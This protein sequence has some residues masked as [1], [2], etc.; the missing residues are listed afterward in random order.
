MFGGNIIW[1]YFD[2]AVRNVVYL[3]LQRRAFVQLAAHIRR[4][5][6]NYKVAAIK[7]ARRSRGT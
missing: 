1:E 4:N 2:D 7:P 6:C 3:I 5:E